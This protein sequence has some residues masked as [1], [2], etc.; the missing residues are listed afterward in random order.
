M[1]FVYTGRVIGWYPIHN[2]NNN[3]SVIDNIYNNITTYTTSLQQQHFY[4]FIVINNNLYLCDL[5]IYCSFIICLLTYLSDI[6]IYYSF[7][8]FYLL[9]FVRIMMLLMEQGT[10]LKVENN[11]Y[12]LYIPCTKCYCSNN[13]LYSYNKFGFA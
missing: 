4:T 6:V 9:F 3:I 2:D 11:N 7:V 5:V 13:N 1:S 10:K 12:F 8:T